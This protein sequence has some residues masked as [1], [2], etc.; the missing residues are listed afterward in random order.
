MKDAGNSEIGNDDVKTG[1]AWKYPSELTG[2]LA[3]LGLAPTEH[4]EPLLVRDALNDLYRY[5]LRRVRD[6]LLAG[7]IAK[8]DYLGIV[9][10]LRRKYWPLSLLPEIWLKVCGNGALPPTLRVQVPSASRS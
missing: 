7:A 10:T 3:N 6:Q 9:V 8:P 4:T 5:E 1:R 2:V